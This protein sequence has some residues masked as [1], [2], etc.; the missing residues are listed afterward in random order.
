MSALYRS[1]QVC[2]ACGLFAG[3]VVV[4]A[5]ALGVETAGRQLVKAATP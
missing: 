4:R 5:A 3:Y 2:C 1:C